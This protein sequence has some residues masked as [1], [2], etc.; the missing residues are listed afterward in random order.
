MSY[1]YTPRLYTRYLFINLN[2]FCYNFRCLTD[3]NTL[4]KQNHTINSAGIF[5]NGITHSDQSISDTTLFV[6]TEEAITVPNILKTTVDDLDDLD[7]VTDS[8]T[9]SDEIILTEGWS[10]IIYR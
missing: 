5:S 6:S 9:I 1:L 4:E 7:D 2:V 8:N 3:N 10:P